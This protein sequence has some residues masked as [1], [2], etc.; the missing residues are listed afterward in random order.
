MKHMHM[1]QGDAKEIVWRINIDEVEL[2]QS[3]YIGLRKS[4]KGRDQPIAAQG[5]NES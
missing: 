5:N 2:F 4:K 3:N 1:L